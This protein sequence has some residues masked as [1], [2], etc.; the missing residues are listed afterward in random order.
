VDGKPSGITAKGICV[1]VCEPGSGRKIEVACWSDATV[2]DLRARLRRV[3]ERGRFRSA[4]EGAG[5]STAADNAD[6][7]AQRLLHGAVVLGADSERLEAFGV[8]DGAVVFPLHDAPTAAILDPDLAVTALGQLKVCPLR[9]RPRAARCGR[10]PR[11]RGASRGRGVAGHAGVARPATLVPARLSRRVRRARQRRRARPHRRG[12]EA[13][14][15]LLLSA[16]AGG[17]GGAVM[18]VHTNAAERGVLERVYTA[19]AFR[20]LLSQ[21]STRARA[22]ER[23]PR[24][25]ALSRGR[26]PGRP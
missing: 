2:G 1:Y 7:T 19:V 3:C 18:C 12:E 16:A 26:S 11:P 17:G 15:A 6:W 21:R 4:H 9:P 14:R 20:S 13:G 10:A 8:C 22:L 23:Q 5:V 25:Q 24:G